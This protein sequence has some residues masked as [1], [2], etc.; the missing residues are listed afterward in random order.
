[1]FRRKDMGATVM[2]TW[3]R[4]D[5]Q[6]LQADHLPHL[7]VSRRAFQQAIRQSGMP[8][9]AEVA[10]PARARFGAGCVMVF[11]PKKP[12]STRADGTAAYPAGTVRPLNLASTDNLIPCSAV[13]LRAEPLIEASISSEQRG[14]L[15]GRPM[16]AN[17]VGI[18]EGAL[19]DACLE[20]IPLA[21]F[22]DIEAAFPSRDQSLLQRVPAKLGWPVWFQRFAAIFGSRDY[23]RLSLCGSTGAGFGIAAGVRQ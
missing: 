15:S 16:L 11:L 17:I 6:H 8:P 12:I 19:A 18:E 22:L 20:D 1:V 23:C 7:A 9:R 5:A 14:F 21:I 4:E 13:R 2:G 3:L 10:H